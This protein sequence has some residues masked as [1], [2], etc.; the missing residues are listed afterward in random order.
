VVVIVDEVIEGGQNDALLRI[1]VERYDAVTT[2]GFRR[3]A[4]DRCADQPLL[5]D[6]RHGCIKQAAATLGDLIFAGGRLGAA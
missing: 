5:G 6:H 2:L 3:D 1:E 4:V